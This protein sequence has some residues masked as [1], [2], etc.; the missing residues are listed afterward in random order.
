[1]IYSRELWTFKPLSRGMWR[2]YALLSRKKDGPKIVVEMNLTEADKRM[3]VGK[4]TYQQIK[5]YILAK[6]GVEVHT[7]YIAEIKRKCGLDVADASNKVENPNQSVHCSE[8]KEK[9]IR[10]AV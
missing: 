4:A 2:R 5:D 6:Y 3:Y 7:Q 9:Y 8:E 1:M 10:E